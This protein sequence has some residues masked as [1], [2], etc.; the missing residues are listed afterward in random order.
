[1][2]RPVIT[3]RRRRVL[4]DIDTQ[5]DFLFSSGACNIR[6]HRRVLANIRRVFAWSRHKNIRVISTAQEYDQRGLAGRNYCLADTPG[7]NKVSYT[8]RNR[9]KEFP[10]DGSTDLP[11]D[12]LREYDQI[13]LNKRCEDPFDEPRADRVFSELRADEFIIIGVPVESAIKFTALGL[14]ARKKNVTLITDAVGYVEKGPAEVAMRQI[15]AKGA[16][17]RDTRSL[18]GSSS[19]RLVGACGCERC[20]GKLQKEYAQANT[21]S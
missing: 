1:M 16:R 5:A 7:H 12:I 10:A 17:L 13:I 18:L 14:L 21:G 20:L 6:N 3:L 11:R 8:L 2:I 15:E 19:L 9:H 4:V